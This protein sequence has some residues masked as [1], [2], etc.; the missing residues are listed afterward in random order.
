VLLRTYVREVLFCSGGC[1]LDSYGVRIYAPLREA[2]SSSIE[3]SRS[4]E[5]WFGTSDRGLERGLIG[6]QALVRIE[7]ANHL[8]AN[9]SLSR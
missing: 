7:G 2:T 8:Q 9:R 6:P 4:K 5:A 1:N 3:D